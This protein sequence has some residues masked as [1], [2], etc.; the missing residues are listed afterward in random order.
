MKA[1]LRSPAASAGARGAPG[2]EPLAALAGIT[3][4][5]ADATSS[6]RNGM[7]RT[8]PLACVIVAPRLLRIVSKVG[9]TSSRASGRLTLKVI[10]PVTSGSIT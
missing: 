8:M 6:L 1:A 2:V 10:G 3:P 7:T 5:P 4:D 9:N